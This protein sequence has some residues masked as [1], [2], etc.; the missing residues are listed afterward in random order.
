MRPIS[1]EI[2][3]VSPELVLHLLHTCVFMYF[4]VSG[5]ELIFTEMFENHT[6]PCTKH[7]NTKRL[8]KQIID[9]FVSD[10]L[11]SWAF[12]W[13]MIIEINYIKFKYNTP[14]SFNFWYSGY[15]TLNQSYSIIT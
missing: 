12:G 2:L 3:F 9:K 4:R 7:K 11:I 5:T 14:K 6:N 8:Y 1:H 10:L 15:V 13:P